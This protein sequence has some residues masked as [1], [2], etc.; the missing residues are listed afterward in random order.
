MEL[1][2]PGRLPG[3]GLVITPAETSATSGAGPGTTQ[4]SRGSRARSARRA[5]ASRSDSQGA[6]QALLAGASGGGKG[7]RW[8]LVN[9][10]GQGGV[11][12]LRIADNLGGARRG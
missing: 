4:V 1:A 3:L 7:N 6:S 11:E 10:Q 12:A 5:S 9:S 2:G 8:S